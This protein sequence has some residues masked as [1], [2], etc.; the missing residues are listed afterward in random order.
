MSHSPGVG[1]PPKK[2]FIPPL[3]FE[4]TKKTTST[5][6]T[7]KVSGETKVQSGLKTPPTTSDDFRTTSP[8]TE[9][10]QTGLG[11]LSN[12]T[13][14]EKPKRGQ[15]KVP[16]L[17]LG[18]TSSTGQTQGGG[19]V[20]KLNLGGTSSTGQTQG[21]GKVPKLNLGGASS[22]GQ[23]GQTQ[24][25][26]QHRPILQRRLGQRL[27]FG[28]Q[29]YRVSKE[30]GEGAYGKAF[31]LRNR[32]GTG[33]NVV[34]K[35]TNPSVVHSRLKGF[36]LSEQDS[37]GLVRKWARREVNLQNM[38]LGDGH[39]SFVPARRI[40]GSGVSM[41]FVGGGDLRKAFGE[42]GQM[43]SSGKISDQQYWGTAQY[44]SREM[45]RG[46]QQLRDKK[47][48]HRDLNPGNVLLDPQTF[49][50]KI[51][52]FGIAKRRSE[53]DY[54]LT[55]KLYLGTGTPGYQSPEAMTANGG[56]HYQ[57]TT[58][59]SDVFSLG[60][61]VEDFG[62]GQ[63]NAPPEFRDFVTKLTDPDRSTRMRID[64]ALQHP[65]LAQPQISDEEAKRVLDQML[66]ARTT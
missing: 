38:A 47:I 44:L 30:L 9:P 4:G 32:N 56:L 54:T 35:Q 48:V 27:Q 63:N 12:D 28:G 62:K 59:R 34:L 64:P 57:K 40:K 11:S 36:G 46:V 24:G 65:F 20:P 5:G 25:T 17:K 8:K 39:P 55:D 37:Q 43:R 50:P 16:P 61:I 58:N 7:Q 33:S 60:K 51:V 15:V 26:K 1:G 18:G 2:P 29:K 6:G 52:D 66:K 53:H 23:T 10:K 22:T 19:K 21:G 49:Q 42:L 14:S 31:L 3:S 45:A 41:D 13:K